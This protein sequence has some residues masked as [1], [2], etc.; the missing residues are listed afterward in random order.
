M[1]LLDTAGKTV[2]KAA[3][4][5]AKAVMPAPR[6]RPLDPWYSDDERRT[7]VNAA[8]DGRSRW[9]G[10]RRGGWLR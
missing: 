5:V 6:E 4:A 10:P 2:K 3:A 1:K 9:L 7:A 8:V